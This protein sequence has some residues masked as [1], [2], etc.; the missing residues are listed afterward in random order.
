MFFAEYW[1]NLNTCKLYKAVEDPEL[2]QRCYNPC[3]KP[4]QKE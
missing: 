2:Q 1:Y 3:L 4:W